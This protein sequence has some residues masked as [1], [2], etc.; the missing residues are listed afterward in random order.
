MTGVK[1]ISMAKHRRSHIRVERDETRLV[2][3]VLIVAAAVICT[4]LIFAF[5]FL[6]SALDDAEEQYMDVLKK[7]KQAVEANKALKME[8]A[9]LSQRGYVEFIA[10][11]R[12]GLK[13]PAD[14]EVVVLR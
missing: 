7:E 3:P 14:G 11:G 12:L 10:Q 13:K 4:T 5:S 9:A 2:K 8:I 1:T 6:S